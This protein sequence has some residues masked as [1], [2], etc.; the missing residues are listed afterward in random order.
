MGLPTL[1]TR[2]IDYVSS[3]GSLRAY[4]EDNQTVVERMADTDTHLFIYVSVVQAI[5]IPRETVSDGSFDVFKQ[6][7]GDYAASGST[8]PALQ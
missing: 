7:V 3:D 6:A 4:L 2:Q 1:K 5:I 8:A